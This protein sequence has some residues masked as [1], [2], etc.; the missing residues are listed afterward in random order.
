MDKIIRWLAFGVL[1][2]ILP[3]ILVMSQ[4]WS[5]NKERAEL[6]FFLDLL[7]VT[8]AVA[9][10]LLGLTT[11][12]KI[13]VKWA[14]IL[15]IIIPVIAMIF[16]V[17]MYFSSF[18]Q[19][20]LNSKLLEQYSSTIDSISKGGEIDQNV[21]KELLLTRELIKELR[22]QAERLSFL[23]N[24]T[25]AILIINAIFGV[26]VEIVDIWYRKKS[27]PPS[28]ENSFKEAETPT[29]DE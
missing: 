26:V 17:A 10:N 18:E 3:L 16:C 27:S 13:I 5:L 24:T 25:L 28:E 6:D 23:R 4:Y 29:L 1:L 21:V 7:L 8:F 22:P 15:C 2:S 12:G 19:I 11:D 14:K 20:I 9:V